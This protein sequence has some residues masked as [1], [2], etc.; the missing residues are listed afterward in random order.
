MLL[1]KTVE[2]VTQEIL[3]INSHVT[4]SPLL[5]IVELNV[6]LLSPAFDPFTFH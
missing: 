3:L 2:A 6:G 1:L 4:I 5:S